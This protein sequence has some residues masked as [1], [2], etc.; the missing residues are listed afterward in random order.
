MNSAGFLSVII[1]KS[2]V[3]KKDINTNPYNGLHVS[4]PKSAHRAQGACMSQGPYR[5]TKVL[6]GTLNLE[7]VIY[8]KA[9][10]KRANQEKMGQKESISF[11]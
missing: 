5:G 4:N 10:R 2:V 6:E 1:S 3:P 9:C 7:H 8:R 11:K